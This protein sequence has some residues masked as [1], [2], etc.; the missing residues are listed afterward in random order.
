MRLSDACTEL[1]AA[2]I[3][4]ADLISAISLAGMAGHVRA[5]GFRSIAIE[6]Q[7]TDGDDRERVRKMF[8]RVLCSP[9]AAEAGFVRIIAGE[10]IAWFRDYGGRKQESY[11]TLLFDKPSFEL[12][13]QEVK[14]RQARQIQQLHEVAAWIRGQTDR[15][16]KTAWRAYKSTF[17]LRAVTQASFYEVWGHVRNHPRRGAP[18]KS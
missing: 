17:G 8:W 18:K 11:E 15:N 6:G 9:K 13:V 10:R 12:F 7:Q 2:G 3:G 16:S 14:A 1:A 5:T 4:T